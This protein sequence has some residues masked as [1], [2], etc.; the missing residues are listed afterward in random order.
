MREQRTSVK[1]KV[2]NETRINHTFIELEGGEASKAPLFHT[3][4]K[5]Y[6]DWRIRRWVGAKGGIATLI[7]HP[8][9]RIQYSRRVV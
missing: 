5:K 2:K 3:E 8:M 4:I 7:T 6:G 1:K 9:P